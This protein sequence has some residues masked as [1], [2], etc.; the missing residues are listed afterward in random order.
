MST[1]TIKSDPMLQKAAVRSEK[2]PANHKDFDATF[3]ARPRSFLATAPATSG[4]VRKRR[5]EKRKVK[6]ETASEP[7]E[8]ESQLRW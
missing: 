7:A 6:N 4:V 5:K 2:P 8:S 1:E 3:D